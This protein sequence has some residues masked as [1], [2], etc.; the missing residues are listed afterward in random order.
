[1]QPPRHK[2]QTEAAPSKRWPGVPC[3]YPSRGPTVQGGEAIYLPSDFWGRGPHASLLERMPWET[4]SPWKPNS[5]PATSLSHFPHN[6]ESVSSCDHLCLFP[7]VR[8]GRRKRTASVFMRHAT[9][10]IRDGTWLLVLWKLPAPHHVLPRHCSQACEPVHWRFRL[11]HC[12]VNLEP[13]P[14][15]A[16]TRPCPQRLPGDLRRHR[17]VLTGSATD[18]RRRRAS[19]SPSPSTLPASRCCWIRES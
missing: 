18:E 10:T 6:L 16:T 9:C 15:C 17:M 2:L 13:D 12:R 4:R 19:P 8:L 11:R 5:R 1:M 14:T 3:I 7:L